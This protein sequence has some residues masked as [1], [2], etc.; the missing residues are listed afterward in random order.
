MYEE[1]RISNIK[2]EETK[3]A[4]RGTKPLL[5]YWFENN[6]INISRLS[7]PISSQYIFN[8]DAIP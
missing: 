2:K 7:R 8:S 1:H 3:N 4:F 6:N 5:L